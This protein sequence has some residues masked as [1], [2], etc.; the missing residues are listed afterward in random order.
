MICRHRSLMSVTTPQ[1][2][3]SRPSCSSQP[4]TTHE[5][6]TILELPPSAEKAY[7]TNPDLMKHLFRNYPGLMVIAR[8]VVSIW[9]RPPTASAKTVFKAWPIVFS[10]DTI[11]VLLVL[12]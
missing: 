9:E 6:I 1:C 3:L 2:A 5:R 11:V 12:L 10:G 4:M 7:I 8:D